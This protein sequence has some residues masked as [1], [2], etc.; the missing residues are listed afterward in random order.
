[1][2]DVETDDE[3]LLANGTITVYGVLGHNFGHVRTNGH[4]TTSIRLPSVA[5]T[6]LLEFVS[7]SVREVIRVVVY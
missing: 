1:V 3:E 2:V 6:Y 5:G 4:R 7:G